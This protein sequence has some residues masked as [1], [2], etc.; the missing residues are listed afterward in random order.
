[1]GPTDDRASATERV[2]L[3]FPGQGGDWR[4]AI[5]CLAAHPEAAAVVAAAEVLGTTDWASLDERD[6]RIAQPVMVAAGLATV[7]ANDESPP[8]WEVVVGH[9][10]GEITAAA[11]AGALRPTEAVHLAALRAEL[12]HRCHQDRPGA[13]AAIVKLEASDLEWLRRSVLADHG[14][15]L[16]VAVVNSAT[17]IV[18]SG[19]H[20]L[21]HEAARR[22]EAAGAVV[23]HLPIGGAFHSPLMASAVDAFRSAATD[24]LRAPTHPVVLSTWP[25]AVTSA[26]ELADRLARS[27]VLPVRWP[28]TM[29]ALVDRGITHLLDAGPGDTLVRLARHLPGPTTTGLPAPTTPASTASTPATSTPGGSA[30]TSNT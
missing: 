25:H 13:M 27:L 19:D 11:A 20:A 14:G 21:L 17:Q 29:D 3:G 2:A 24:V 15:V 28:E 5:R 8:P 12:G 23:R 22:A 26:E 18:L 9:S 4:A 7:E 10:L 6:T 16:E 1:M 30:A